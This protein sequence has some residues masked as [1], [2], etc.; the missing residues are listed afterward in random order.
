MR[1]D[2]LGTEGGLAIDRDFPIVVIGK[3]ARN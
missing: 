2:V 3:G 1:G